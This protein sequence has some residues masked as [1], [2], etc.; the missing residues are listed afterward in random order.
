M[1]K[2]TKIILIV[3]AILVIVIASLGIYY[4]SQYKKADNAMNVMSTD[5]EAGLEMCDDI[6]SNIMQDECYGAYFARKLGEITMK[7][8]DNPNDINKLDELS[9]TADMMCI[10]MNRKEVKERCLMNTMFFDI[11][12]K[13]MLMKEVQELLNKS[14]DYT[15]Q[16]GK[17]CGGK[18]DCAYIANV[19]YKNSPFKRIVFDEEGV[20]QDTWPKCEPTDSN[21]LFQKETSRTRFVGGI[22]YNF[23]INEVGQGYCVIS[24]ATL[25]GIEE[26]IRLNRNETGDLMGFKIRINDASPDDEFCG[27]EIIGDV[28]DCRWGEPGRAVGLFG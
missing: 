3:T 2:T 22:Q 27:F 5:L 19:Q 10:M 12:R 8:Q 20:Y 25:S 23:Y 21:L 1:Y 26:Q 15:L 16:V 18:S 14:P 24:A 7:Y 28:Q 11:E 17:E 4:Y 13:A 9:Q 6:S